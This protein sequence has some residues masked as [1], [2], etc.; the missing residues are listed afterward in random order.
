[1]KLQNIQRWQQTGNYTFTPIA[2]ETLGALGADT[3]TFFSELGRRLQY[4]TREQCAFMFLMQRISVAL[5]R[6]SA[7]CLLGSL[8]PC[9]RWDDALYL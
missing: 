8:P 2:I 1:V 7:T 9:G 5:Q 4:A 6:G 3:S